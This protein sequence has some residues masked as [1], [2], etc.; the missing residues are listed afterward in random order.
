[1]RQA[2]AALLARKRKSEDS[3]VLQRRCLAALGWCERIEYL[4]F[5]LLLLFFENK[6]HSFSLSLGMHGL[7]AANKKNSLRRPK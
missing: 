2:T 6:N 5:K 7:S 4:M 1:M 3:V